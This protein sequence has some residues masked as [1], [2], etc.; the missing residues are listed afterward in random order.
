MTDDRLEGSAHNS[1]M[2]A[3]LRNSY[4]AGRGMETVEMLRDHSWPRIKRLAP[5]SQCVYYWRTLFHCF[6]SR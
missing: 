2:S 1:E 3:L 5:K 6:S 4:Q